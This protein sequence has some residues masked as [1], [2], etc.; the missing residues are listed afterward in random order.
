MAPQL[1]GP[2]S[3]RRGASGGLTLCT[4]SF[5]ETEVLLLISVLQVKFGMICSIQKAPNKGQY[6]I[7]IWAKSMPALRALVQSPPEGGIEPPRGE[8]NLIFMILC[9][10]N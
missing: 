1:G 6:R 7:Y 10:I 3:V 2:P 4:D 8:F 9:Y 5:T